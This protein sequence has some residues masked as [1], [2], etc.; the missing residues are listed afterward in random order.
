MG[1][2]VADLFTNTYK[3]EG[4]RCNNIIRSLVYNIPKVL[5]MEE[6]DKLK[7]KVLEEEVRNVFFSMK[8]CKAS[9]SNGFLLAFF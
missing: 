5:A 8:I 4:R 6:N 1:R 3:R 7:E 2:N 9:S